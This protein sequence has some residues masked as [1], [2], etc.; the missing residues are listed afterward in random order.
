M[1]HK[2]I[3]GFEMLRWRRMEKVNWTERVIDE[4]VLQS[5]ILR[6]MKKNEGQLDWSNLA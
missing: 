6:K 2:Y 5:S 4:E 1:N 3:V